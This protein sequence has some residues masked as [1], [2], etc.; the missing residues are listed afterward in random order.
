MKTEKYSGVIVNKIKNILIILI[1]SFL[2][3]FFNIEYNSYENEIINRGYIEQEFIF[4]DNLNNSKLFKE[5]KCYKEKEIIYIESGAMSKN[6][7]KYNK[8]II[9]C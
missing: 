3:V 8:G 9:I 7:Y 5:N 6:L 1:I 2:T 4:L